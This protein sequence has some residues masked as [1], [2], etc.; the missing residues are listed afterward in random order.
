[1]P[2]KNQSAQSI[3][4]V[5]F[6]KNK[7]QV[8][9][10]M[11]RDVPVWV[12]PGGGIEPSETPETAIV[13]EMEE[14]TGYL[15]A[16]TRLVGNYLPANRLTRK[17]ALF[18]C[19]IISGAAKTGPE[20]RAIACFSVKDLPKL[21]PPPYQEWIQDALAQTKEP[22][23]KTLQGITYVLLLKFFL[24]HPLLVTRF[25]LSRMGIFINS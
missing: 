1:M 21:M 3:A 12:L 24:R 25:L 2:D 17:T 15:V 10:I 13:R 22:L 11:R 23:E 8:L 9:L 18:E 19:K 14:E 20:T 16:I 7:E 4:G 6:T 5:I